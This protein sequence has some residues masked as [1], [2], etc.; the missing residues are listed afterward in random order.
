MTSQDY[1]I[2]INDMWKYRWLHQSSPTST[3]CIRTWDLPPRLGSR[4][5]TI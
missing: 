3:F 1:A 4:L 5:P 2:N